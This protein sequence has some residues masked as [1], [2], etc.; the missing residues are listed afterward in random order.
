VVLCESVTVAL[1]V[2]S[3]PFVD[4]VE[5]IFGSAITDMVAVLFELN[6]V[7]QFA[8]LEIAVTV[9]VEFPEVVKPVA[10]NVP[11]PAVDTVSVAVK[12]FCEGDDLL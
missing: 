12:P 6:E 11:V 3:Q 7:L 2:P 5:L 8:E 4:E 10:V 9:M 1:P